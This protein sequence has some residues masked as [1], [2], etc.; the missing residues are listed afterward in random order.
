[1]VAL[2]IGSGRTMVALVMGS[3]RTMVATYSSGDP[4]DEYP[5]S[6]RLPPPPPLHD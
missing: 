2:V 4:A 5:P 6:A 3:G 1:M